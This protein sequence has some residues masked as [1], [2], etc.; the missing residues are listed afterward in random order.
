MTVIEEI[1]LKYSQ[2]PG[3]IDK[4]IKEWISIHPD[5][6][7]NELRKIFL[8]PGNT[9]NFEIMSCYHCNEKCV[10]CF[11]ENETIQMPLLKDLYKL[12]DTIREE[13][14][15]CIIGGEPTLR[16]DLPELLQ[17]IKN[18]QKIINLSTNGLRL[19]DDVFLNKI[20]PFIDII[21]FPIHSSNFDIFDAI[22][23]VKNSGYKS[24]EVFKKLISLDE[25]MIIT[26]TV[27]NKLNYRS[28]LETFDMIQNI[29][30][31][32]MT[33][34]FPH[35][36]GNAHSNNVVPKYSEIKE[37]ISKVLSKYGHLINT[38]DIP[39]C[40]LYPYQDIVINLDNDHCGT[41]DYTQTRTKVPECK[42]C[43]FNNECIGISKRYSELYSNIDLFPI[44]GL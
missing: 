23:Q 17:Y 24:I 42:E 41:V 14:V 25:L 30:N 29:S 15:V 33:L 11:N 19:S 38:R 12:I 44:K 34:T 31:V 35:P 9:K 10:H 37:Y 36:V 3:F 7:L 39:R 22:T 1:K 27:I 32:R 21:S 40:Y 43:V 18:K 4:K 16:D 26:Q 2:Y 13:N 28:L 5:D 8:E 6:N 20:I